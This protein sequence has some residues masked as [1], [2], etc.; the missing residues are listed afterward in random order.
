MSAVPSMDPAALAASPRATID[1]T[2]FAELVRAFNEVTA[3]LE[4][5]HGSLQREVAMQLQFKMLK[6]RRADLE[7]T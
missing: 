1:A 7:I 5:T 6:F 3:R 4:S 2:E